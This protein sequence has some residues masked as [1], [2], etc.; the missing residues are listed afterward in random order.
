MYGPLK[1]YSSNNASP[2]N[3]NLKPIPEDNKGLEKLPQGVRNK[4]GFMRYADGSEPTEM[5]SPMPRFCGGMSKPY[6]RK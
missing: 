3:K 2:I 4:M 1:K 5:P 6:K